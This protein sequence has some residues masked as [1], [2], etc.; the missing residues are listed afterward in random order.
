MQPLKMGFNYCFEQW[1]T[2]RLHEM[3]KLSGNCEKGTEFKINKTNL[4]TFH[5]FWNSDAEILELWT[6]QWTTFTFCFDLLTHIVF[7]SLSISISL[8]K[9]IFCNLSKLF[10]FWCRSPLVDLILGGCEQ[11]LTRQKCKYIK[12]KWVH[13]FWTPKM[14]TLPTS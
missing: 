5:H 9:C 3:E 4:S 7:L 8:H 14:L 2:K 1:A 13:I 11:R 6:I 10:Y 12:K